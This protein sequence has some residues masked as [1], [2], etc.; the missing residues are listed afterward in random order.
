MEICAHL[1]LL[2]GTANK[3]T[4][5]HRFTGKDDLSVHAPLRSGCIMLC[6]SMHSNVHLCEWVR[7]SVCCADVSVCLCAST[8]WECCFL[9]FIWRAKQQLVLTADQTLSCRPFTQKTN[10]GQEGMRVE[11]QK[12]E[13]LAVLRRADV[14]GNDLWG[15]GNCQEL[16]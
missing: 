4:Q 3:L 15:N 14:P 10:R 16:F 2:R 13:C 8:V 5:S 1:E 9:S 11:T 12:N 7:L 6:L